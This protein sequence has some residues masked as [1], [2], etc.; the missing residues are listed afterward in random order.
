MSF[1]SYA[2]TKGADQPAHSPRRLICAFVVR[3]LDG[4]I[5]AQA[6]LCLA[7]LETPEDAFCRGAAHVYRCYI[8]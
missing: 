6:G 8:D 7:W 3:G 1:K 5:S 2:N 4:I